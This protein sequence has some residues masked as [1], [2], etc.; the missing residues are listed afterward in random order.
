[1]PHPGQTIDNPITGE[2][3]R[4]VRT[5]AE[6]R[7]PAVRERT[8]LPG[9]PHERRPHAHATLTEIFEV[10]EGEARY[11]LG[12][13]ERALVAGERVEMPP[14]VP[15]VHPWNVGSGPLRV[16]QAVHLQGN[17]LAGAAAVE[18]YLVTTFG[19]AREGRTAADGR[20]PLLQVAVSLHAAYPH[21]YL[22]GVPGSVQRTLFAILAP[23]GRAAGYRAKYARFDL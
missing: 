2:S 15:H 12:D 10:L 13:E 6:G 7:G 17:D 3:I 18:D 23:I 21:V 14:N 19:L 22:A 11:R 8:V 20:A 4:F 5:F 9:R 16:R 1:M